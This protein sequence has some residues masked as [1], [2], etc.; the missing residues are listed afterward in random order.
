MRLN[1]SI[2]SIMVS[3]LFLHQN[4]Q[5]QEMPEH[6]L[7][8]FSQGIINNAGLDVGDIKKM[9]IAVSRTRGEKRSDSELNELNNLSLIEL[10]QLATQP[11]EIEFIEVPERSLKRMGTYTTEASEFIAPGEEASPI[12]F[13]HRGETWVRWFIHPMREDQSYRRFLGQTQIQRGRFLALLTESRSVVVFDRHETKAWTIKLSLPE[14]VGSFN[15]KS[16]PARDAQVHFRASEAIL[17]SGALANHQDL[18]ILPEQ[19]YVGIESESFNEAQLVRNIDMLTPGKT[20]IPFSSFFTTEFFRSGL[21][22]NEKDKIEWLARKPGKLAALIYEK[23]GLLHNSNHSQNSMLLLGENGRPLQML[24]RDHDYELDKNHRFAEHTHRQIPSGIFKRTAYVDYSMVNGMKERFPKERF[25]DYLK[26]ALS[27]FYTF[28][29]TLTGLRNEDYDQKEVERVLRTTPR[30]ITEANLL[31]YELVTRPTFDPRTHFITL[32]TDYFNKD[33]EIR[34]LTLTEVESK[35]LETLELTKTRLFKAFPALQ[36]FEGAPYRSIESILLT[37]TQRMG[38]SALPTKEL[39]T[40]FPEIMAQM[41]LKLIQEYMDTDLRSQSL[42]QRVLNENDKAAFWNLCLMIKHFDLNLHPDFFHRFV[43]QSARLDIGE[44]L[45]FLFNYDSPLRSSEKH[46][47]GLFE[48]YIK[49]ASLQERHF[50][51]QKKKD[52]LRLSE[53]PQ[54]LEFLTQSKSAIS[55]PGA[56]CK[57]ALLRTATQ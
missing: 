39:N 47:L 49:N 1:L 11:F 8:S 10:K 37:P 56:S 34:G 38:V 35:K 20:L 29:E 2:I 32:I 36:N 21:N 54:L 40:I 53:Y 4:L 17:R 15:D 3:L 48:T 31:T 44:G 26:L 7:K 14:A 27:Y 46:F 52:S 6:L 12:R 16:Y 57:T 41:E 55:E 18:G 9:A 30:E 19:E 33:R 28:F 13:K 23:M 24:L 43:E 22:W 50:I 45:Y 51:L 25:N 5:A 42:I